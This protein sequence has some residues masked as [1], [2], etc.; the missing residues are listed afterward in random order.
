MPAKLPAFAYDAR[1]FLS[2][3]ARFP[4]NGSGA[5]RKEKKAEPKFTSYERRGHK[6]AVRIPRGNDGTHLHVDFA[7]ESYFPEDFFPTSNAKVSLLTG[8]VEGVTGRT[9]QVTVFGG[10][11]VALNRIPEHVVIRLLS[12]KGI[13]GDSG[14]RLTAGELTFKESSIK[15]LEWQVLESEDAEEERVKIGLSTLLEET[16]DEDY[17]ARAEES[18]DRLF[19]IF[20]LGKGRKKE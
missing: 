18:A 19:E 6:I 13:G 16:I 2:V 12:G 1:E 14:V 8:L 5:P 4:K 10:Y 20:V 15:S 9:A 17:F 7:A 11:K 3:C